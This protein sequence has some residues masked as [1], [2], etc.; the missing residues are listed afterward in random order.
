M[1]DDIGNFSHLF[2][3]DAKQRIREKIVIDLP[4]GIIQTDTDEEAAQLPAILAGMAA[5]R[6]AEIAAGISAVLPMAKCGTNLE[7]AK[8]E[9]LKERKLRM[10]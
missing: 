5:A 8:S 3:P 7:A 2:K 6:Q 4:K 9:F 1:N 10:V